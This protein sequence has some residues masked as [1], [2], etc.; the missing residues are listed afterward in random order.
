MGWWHLKEA[1]HVH[2]MGIMT[3]NVLTDSQMVGYE[4]H[5]NEFGRRAPQTPYP[6]VGGGDG[7]EGEG[8]E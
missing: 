1:F 3:V 6:S 7:R 5:Q 2:P 8:L 4:L